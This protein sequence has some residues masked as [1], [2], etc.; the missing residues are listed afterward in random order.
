MLD[1]ATGEAE[2]GG[3]AAALAVDDRRHVVMRLSTV[4]MATAAAAAALT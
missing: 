3:R 4:T 2:T 1:T